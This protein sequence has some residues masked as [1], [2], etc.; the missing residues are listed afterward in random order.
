[1]GSISGVRSRRIKTR[2]CFANKAGPRFLWGL[3]GKVLPEV[4]WQR[5]ADRL[6]DEIPQQQ[7][8]TWIRP[9]QASLDGFYLTLFAPNRFRWDVGSEKFAPRISQLLLD[10]GSQVELKMQVDAHLAE[11]V[12]LVN[13]APVLDQLP[14][15]SFPEIQAVDLDTATA[16]RHAQIRAPMRRHHAGPSHR[17]AV[18]AFGEQSIEILLPAVRERLQPGCLVESAGTLEPS[19]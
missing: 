1:M 7:F 5:C 3:K 17:S 15:F 8:N 13:E 2:Y 4:L 6:Q 12:N 18:R 19:S 11:Q 14:A 10:E 16:R 9:L